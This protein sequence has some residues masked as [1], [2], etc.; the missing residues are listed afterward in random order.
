[1]FIFNKVKPLK[2]TLLILCFAIVSAELD[3]QYFPS[4]EYTAQDGIPS[5]SVFDIAQHP[6]G[7]MWFLTKSGPTYYDASRWHSFSDTLL[8]PSSSNAKIIESDSIMWVAGLN[9]TDFTLQYFDNSWHRIDVPFDSKLFNNHIAFNVFN[10]YAVVGSRNQLFIYDFYNDEWSNQEIG[11]FNINSIHEIGDRWIITTSNG[12]WEYSENEFKKIPLAYDQLPSQNILTLTDRNDTLALLG[13][14][15]Y[16]EFI[17]EN[18]VTLIEDLGMNRSSPTTQSSLIFSEN[19]MVLFSANTPA[20]LLDVANGT[21]QNLLIKGERFNIGS[22]RIFRDRENNVWV[23]DSRGLFKFNLLQFMNYNMSSGLA[24]DEVT[25]VKELRTG[26]MLVANPNHLNFIDSNKISQYS[27]EVDQHLTFRILDI[28]EDI[29]NDQLLVAA[30]DGGLIIY[31]ANNYENPARII[32][33]N[34][35]RATT[36]EVFQNEIYAAGNQGFYSYKNQTLNK[37]NTILGI[38]N[39]DVLGDSLALLTTSKGLY[40]FSNDSITHHNSSNFDLKSVYKAVRFSGDIVLAT[41]DGLGTI[42]EE[43]EIIRW[44]R[45]KINAPVYGLKVDSKQRLWI[46][47]NHGVYL[48]DNESL[49]LYNSSEGLAGSEINR[50]AL[51]E[52]TR[53][54]IWIG[55]EKGVSVFLG[56]KE[57]NKSLN[58]RVDITEIKTNQNRKL[59]SFKDNSMPYKFNSLEISYQ[60]LSYVDESK[61]NFRYR[62]DKSPDDKWIVS[63]NPENNIIFSNI[64]HGSY[65]FEIQARL[66]TGEWGPITSFNFTIEKPYYMRWW[67]I[68]LAAVVLIAIGR[69]IFYFRYKLLIKK[70]KRLKE[71]VAIRTKEIRMLNEQLEEKVLER[72]KELNDKN[73]QLEESAYVNAHYLRGPLTKIMSALQIAESNEHKVLDADIIKILKE[74]TDELDQVIHSINEILRE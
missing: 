40:L 43:G 20:R 33:G 45:L 18:L 31:D 71:Q 4:R 23:S 63:D 60:C 70:Q 3:A 58:L 11:A 46:G 25:V 74:S 37:I 66:D 13:F 65:Q 2:S 5:N 35:F 28:E 38:R 49:T 51:I 48:Y 42:S 6:S 32:E 9:K 41:R 19:K 64:Q 30:N 59:S 50:N 53:G 17:N 8:L 62:I 57:L 52:D 16:A 61:I 39:M 22:T 24:N 69:T 36:L 7:V 29:E 72:T 34:G 26:T 47:T 12:L 1:M 55:A 44:P 73:L 68:L 54:R 67:F 10:H 27:L 21:W 15:W 14:D 56:K